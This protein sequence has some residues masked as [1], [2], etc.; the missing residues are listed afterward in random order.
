MAEDPL[1]PLE[2]DG[3]ALRIAGR[4]DR[5]DVAP[6][7]S[8]ALVYDYKG[9][10]TTD[11]AHWVADR[12]WQIALYLIAVKE[13][14]DLE[15]VGGLYQ[16]LGSK[17]LRPRGALLADADPGLGVVARDRREADDLEALV[18]EV[19]AEVLTAIG[20]L[21]AGALEP[22]PATCAYGGGCSYPMICRSEA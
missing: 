9:R 14:L 10:T 5:I 19:V 7:R 15:P 12:K 17:D 16:P 22:R 8:D 6:G 20:E 4:I 2:L 11:G 1:P 21:R 3:G 13:L 18:D